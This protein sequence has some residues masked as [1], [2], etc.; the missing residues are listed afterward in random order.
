MFVSVVNL[1]N[2]ANFGGFSGMM[3]SPFYRRATLVQNPR[4]VDLGL[5]I[6]F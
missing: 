2:R 3:T 5:N 1:T 6:A 4:K